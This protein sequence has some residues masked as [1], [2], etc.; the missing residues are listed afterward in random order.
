MDKSKAGTAPFAPIVVHERRTHSCGWNRYL[1]DTNWVYI[2]TCF[3]CRVKM[4]KLLDNCIDYYTI[5]SP[6]S[7]TKYITGFSISA[8][9]PSLSEYD[10]M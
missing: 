6:E 8:K 1:T 9:K 7:V 3:G 5:S 4:D 10:R 2:S